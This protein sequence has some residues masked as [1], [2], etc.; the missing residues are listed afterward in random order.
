VERLMAKTDAQI[1]DEHV[2]GAGCFGII[3]TD[4]KLKIW[5]AGKRRAVLDYLRADNG[6][7]GRLYKSFLLFEG[8]R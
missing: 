2:R 5:G 8:S 6:W 1:I 4:D 3:D 7:R